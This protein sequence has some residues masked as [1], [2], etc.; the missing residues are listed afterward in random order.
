MGHNVL[1]TSYFFKSVDN[2]LDQY[3]KKNLLPRDFNDQDTEP[4]LSECL[5]QYEAKNLMK[6]NTCF[7]NPDRPTCIGLF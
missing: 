2:A 6:N 7:K 3:L 5:E 4:I 1:T